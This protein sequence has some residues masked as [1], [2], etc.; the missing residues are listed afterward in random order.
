MS[1]L[2][3]LIRKVFSA[4]KRLEAWATPD[5]WDGHD[6]TKDDTAYPWLSW[7]TRQVCA[8]FNHP[9]YAWGTLLG[10]L[11][12]QRLAIKRVSVIEF[13]V[14]GGRGL[15]ALEGIAQ[16]AGALLNLQ[17]DTY[18]FDTGTGLPKPVDYRDRPNAFAE[19][20]FAMDFTALRDRLRTAQLILGDIAITLQRF[21]AGGPAPIAFISMDVD[22]YSSTVAALQVLDAVTHSLLPRIPV[23]FDDVIGFS[24]G[25]CNGEL[26]AI[27]DF[28]ATHQ[29]RKVSR[30]PGLRYFI[31]PPYRDQSWVEMMYLAHTFDH[32]LY[33]VYDGFA[34][35]T[36]PL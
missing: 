11:Y 36:L 21:L 3:P 22:L 8:H 31:T 2:R 26:L 1:I 17:V 25:D 35:R 24:T 18:G 16:R 30:V 6:F 7:A 10:C 13:G 32:P 9:A 20:D 4:A 34:R 19:G 29:T 23:Y 12:A 14:A 5:P 15:L 28:N 33:N 27:A